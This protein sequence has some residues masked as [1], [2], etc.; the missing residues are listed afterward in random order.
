MGDVVEKQVI[1]NFAKDG[2]LFGYPCG[3]GFIKEKLVRDG[4][5]ICFSPSK[6]RVHEIF[7]DHDAV[8]YLCEDCYERLAKPH[9]KK[10]GIKVVE[11]SKRI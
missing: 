11:D 7:G 4:S 10:R 5:A 8:I 9:Y 6:V 2:T 1:V 3:T